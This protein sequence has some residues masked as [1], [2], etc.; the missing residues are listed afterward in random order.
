MSRNVAGLALAATLFATGCASTGSP[1]ALVAQTPN[2]DLGRLEVSARC[3]PPGVTGVFFSWPVH[4]F[5]PM[6][7]RRDD[8]TLVRAAWVLYR[9]GDAEV[10]ALWGGEELLA[11]DPSP[12]TDTPVWFDTGL[13][14]GEGK[15]L[16]VDTTDKC[17]WRQEGG[18]MARA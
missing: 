18:Q 7:I 16:R 3:L 10:A 5:R 1:S 17:H 13:M 2:Q 4:A 9:R 11:V 15:T 14:D 8:D 12:R 6:L